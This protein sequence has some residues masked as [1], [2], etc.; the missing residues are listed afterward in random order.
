MSKFDEFRKASH[1]NY[2]NDVFLK[3]L[4][5]AKQ[6]EIQAGQL[7]TKKFNIEIMNFND[8]YKYDFITTDHIKYEVKADKMALNTN[9]YFIEFEGYGKASG[10]SIT[11]AH[12]YILSNTLKY[13]LITVDKLKYICNK[14]GIIKKVKINETFGFII[15]SNKVIKHSELL[16]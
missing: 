9:N 7:I 4:E 12:Y 2:Y 8:D 15:P 1:R 16:G 6:Y 13:Y 11:E 5:E 14:Y 3:R 10:L